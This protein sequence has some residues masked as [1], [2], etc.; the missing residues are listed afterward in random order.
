MAG[1]YK[2]DLNRY[3]ELDGCSS[4]KNLTG[5][6][7]HEHYVHGQPGT[8]ECDIEWPQSM[9]DDIRLDVFETIC[10]EVCEMV[11]KWRLQHPR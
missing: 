11:N 1:A 4:M 10:E 6:S 7:R 9:P 5:E 3:L 2:K 8:R